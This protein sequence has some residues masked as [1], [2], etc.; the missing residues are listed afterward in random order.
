MSKMDININGKRPGLTLEKSEPKNKKTD[1]KTI[2]QIARHIWSRDFSKARSSNSEDREFCDFFGCCDS[3]CL[4]L[5]EMMVDKLHLPPGGNI[6]HLLWALMFLKSYG[7]QKV[8]SALAGGV[9]PQTF[10]K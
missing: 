5:W 1:L 4:V 9:D 6:E 3:V 8:M 10:R 7:K 2:L